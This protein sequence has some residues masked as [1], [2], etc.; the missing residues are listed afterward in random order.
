[1][2]AIPGG[3]TRRT[4]GTAFWDGTSWRA[5]IGGNLV[6]CRW[7]DPV[8]PVQ[9]GC[10]VVDITTDERGQ[11]TAL[12][13]GS[14][15]DQPRP[16]TGSVLIPGVSEIL[17]TGEDG[18]TYTTDRFIGT[19]AIGDPVYISWDGASPTIVGK[20]PAVKVTPK[21]NTPKPP[22]GGDIAGTKRTP[23]TRSDT[24]DPA[25]GWGDWGSAALGG[26]DVYAGP[27]SG[28]TLTGAWFYGLGNTIL[29]GRTID[30]VRFR[31]PGRLDVGEPGAVTVHLYAHT[32]SS[33]PGG[34]LTAAA[35]PFDVTVS[36]DGKPS[37]V[38]L[39]TSF[40]SILAAGG[41]IF[42]TAD[43]YVGFRG[44]LQDTNSGKLESDWTR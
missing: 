43:A 12:V 19:Y 32:R 23:A 35:G 20:I 41:G 11:A 4:Y 39:P 36:D 8:Q 25:N 30:E 26:E 14:Y 22:G 16:S 42:I 33:I 38:V 3:R 34:A 18:T 7:M 24:F 13:V 40:Y 2:A 29:A 31:L 44:R 17:F 28:H 37:W 10:L 15:A 1:M 27:Q 21:A 9:G 5:N 6:T